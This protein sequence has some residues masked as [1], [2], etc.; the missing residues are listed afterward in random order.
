MGGAAPPRRQAPL[1]GAGVHT[2]AF[3]LRVQRL[4][5]EYQQTPII[6]FC[7]PFLHSLANAYQCREF[8]YRA[9]DVLPPVPVAYRTTVRCF[10]LLVP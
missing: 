4:L 2:L 9:S 8:E 5:H 10:V 6:I 1:Q 7:S 3:R